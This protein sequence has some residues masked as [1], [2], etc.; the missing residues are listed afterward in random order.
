MNIKMLKATLA[1]LILSI[2]SLAN[3]GIIELTW[4]T[5]LSDTDVVGTNIGDNVSLVFR[6]NST[7]NDLS[8]L[9]LN[10]NSFMDYSFHLD[11]GR[12]VTFDL[13][14]SGYI[15]SGYENN[16]FFSFDALGDLV[17]IESFYILDTSVVSNIVGVNGTS[18]GM[19]NNGANCFLCGGS[20][21]FGVNNV[22]SGLSTSSWAV[23][24]SQD[25]PEPST[26]A[27]FALGMIGLASRRFKKQ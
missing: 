16:S 4:D 15:N 17:G 14:E 2:S 23:S 13:L 1:G 26:L 9:V 12:F 5:S 7:T 25:V 24:Q 21:Y 10:K 8:N 3:A 20:Q 18:Q 11:D 19:F 6:F 22:A 27:I